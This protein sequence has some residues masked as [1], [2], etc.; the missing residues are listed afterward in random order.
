MNGSPRPAVLQA[1]QLLEDT[2]KKTLLSIALIPALLFALSGCG[3]TPAAEPQTAP[4][5]EAEPARRDGER[6]ESTIMLEGMEETVRYEHI[7]NETAGF[8][9]D[10]DYER[11][12][13]RSEPGRE[14]FVS[15][16]DDPENPENYL[17][18]TYS[19]QDAETVAE[20]VTESLSE[21]YDLTRV[22]RELDKAG[23]CIRIEAS[24]IRNTNR[25]T[26][27]LRAV[28]IIPAP[29]GCRIAT[30]HCFIVESEGFFRRFDSM[31]DTM[32]VIERRASRVRNYCYASNPELEGI[33]TAGE[34]QVY[35]TVSSEEAGEIVVLFRS[36]TGAEIRYYIDRITGD[37]YAT[38]FVPGITPAE[39]RTQESFN[40]WDYMD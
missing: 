34:Y 24:V 29:D 7:V 16:W 3:K 38:E 28:Y 12:A 40:L 37:A 23:S 11:F 39:E 13:R 8:E 35:W 4:T 25:M 22:T 14:S 30:A 33:V 36:Y 6:Y 17:E 19:T 2:M 10:Y 26:E 31:L 5:A 18:V 21:E 20:A 9:M 27:Q 15:V 1:E 32:T